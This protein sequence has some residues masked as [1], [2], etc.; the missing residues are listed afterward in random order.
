MLPNIFESAKVGDAV[1]T[2]SGG[3]AVITDIDNS[4]R[5]I[6]IGSCWYRKDGCETSWSKYPSCWPAHLVPQYYLDLCPRPKRK[7]VK[8][9]NGIL[10]L[11]PHGNIIGFV[12]DVNHIW[13]GFRAAPFTGTYEVEE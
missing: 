6:G 4:N 10:M 7:V 2:V 1:F 9:F 3:W 11:S 5:P 8:E 13:K 12:D